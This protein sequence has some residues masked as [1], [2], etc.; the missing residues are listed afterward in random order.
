[1]IILRF[2]GIV[3]T[4]DLNTCPHCS[5]E[6]A[7]DEF[8]K[9]ESNDTGAHTDV[10]V[11]WSSHVEVIHITEDAGGW[12]PTS[13]HQKL[14]N[15][16]ISGWKR[17]RDDIGPGLQQGHPLRQFLS[18]TH[19][20]ALNDGFF[21]WQKRLFEAEGNFERSLSMDE[22]TPP[23]PPPDAPSSWPEMNDLPE[24]RKLRKIVEK[25]SRRYLARSGMHPDVAQ[26]LNYSLFNWA[27]VHGPGEFHGPHTHVG[28]YHVGVFYAQA[29]PAAGKL[30][31]GDPRGHSPPFGRSFFHTPRSG[32]LIFFPSW[33]SHMATVTAPSSDIINKGE[34]PYRVVF[35]FNIG[36][37]SGPL[38]CHLW[39]SDPTGDMRFKRRSKL[40][41]EELRAL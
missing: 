23:T 19:A 14:A 1:M 22:D 29:G 24:Y 36:P 8:L 39:W 3:H 16:A 7:F 31:F 15:E 38:P 34:E 13:F 41:E 17:F 28:E 27:A 11:L 37:I 10:H 30:R 21:H 25:L 35:S 9:P 2:F 4:F 32:D 12:E 5:T 6:G 40:N 33:L 18:Q 20:G 26:G